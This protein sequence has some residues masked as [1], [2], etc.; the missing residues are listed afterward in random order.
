MCVL[1]FFESRRLLQVVAL[2]FALSPNGRASE[3]D[4]SFQACPPSLSLADYLVG[5]LGL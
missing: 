1:V 3:Q 5:S 4:L 2:C